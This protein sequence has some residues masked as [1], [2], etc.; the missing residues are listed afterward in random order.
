[1]IFSK[2][3]YIKYIDNP[4]YIFKSDSFFVSSKEKIMAGYSSFTVLRKLQNDEK[5]RKAQFRYELQKK[6][7]KFLEGAL[8]GLS[9]YDFPDL[10]NQ[11]MQVIKD[12]IRINLRQD[13]VNSRRNSLFLFI[14]A[15]IVVFCLMIMYAQEIEERVNLRQ[16]L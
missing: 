9:G 2:K 3:Q 1:L 13:K 5:F 8:G 14:I 7:E 4:T 15:A 16:I 6:K 11:E 10:T 12:Q